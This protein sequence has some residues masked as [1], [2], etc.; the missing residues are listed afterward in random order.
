LPKNQTGIIAGR[1]SLAID[2]NAAE[3]WNRIKDFATLPTEKARDKYKL[4]PDARDWGVQRAQEDIHSNGLSK[5]FIRH[6]LYRPF[7]SRFIYYTLKSR[8]FIRWPY[9]EFMQHIALH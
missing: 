8:G 2:V 9:A 3:L 7:D 4:G 1:D 6:I 5:S